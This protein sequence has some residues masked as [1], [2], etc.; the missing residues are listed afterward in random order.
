MAPLIINLDNRCRWVATFTP[1][2]ALGREGT[3]VR[4]V[5]QIGWTPEQVYTASRK[6]NSLN[7][8][9]IRVLYV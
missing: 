6:E 3:P 8:E 2:A 9:G 7:P 4:S 1:P 5:Q